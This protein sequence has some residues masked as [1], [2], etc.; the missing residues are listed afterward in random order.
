MN[1]HKII[2]KLLQKIIND[3][4]LR[5]NLLLFLLFFIYCSLLFIYFF[6]YNTPPESPESI[7]R[8]RFRGSYRYTCSKNIGKKKRHKL[9]RKFDAF[10]I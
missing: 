1:F 7:K 2:K 4:L 8:F 3:I 9:Y 10:M 5:T 6:L